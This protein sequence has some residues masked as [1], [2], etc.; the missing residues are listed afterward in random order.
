MEAFILIF[1]IGILF[2]IAFRFISGFEFIL[3]LIFFLCL[4]ISFIGSILTEEFKLTMI[5]GSIILFIVYRMRQVYKLNDN[6]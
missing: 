6:D 5:T 1:V 2:L 3:F 4:I